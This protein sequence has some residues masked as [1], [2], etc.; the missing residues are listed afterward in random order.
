MVLSAV[1]SSLSPFSSLYSSARRIWLVCATTF[2]AWQAARR[3]LRGCTIQA[4]RAK[5]NSIFHHWCKRQM[6]WFVKDYQFLLIAAPLLLAS[7]CTW[8]VN[9][10]VIKLI[11]ETNNV[12][13]LVNA[14]ESLDATAPERRK[15]SLQRFNY[16]LNSTGLWLSRTGFVVARIVMPW[17]GDDTTAV[18]YFSAV[19]WN[20]AN[21]R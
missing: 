1:T 19:M 18:F 16:E 9:A 21:D 13:V 8:R 15:E 11:S 2:V 5:R 7:R 3:V 17:V 14:S 10:L 20:S 6:R 12:T 4:Q